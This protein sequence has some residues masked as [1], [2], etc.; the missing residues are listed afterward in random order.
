MT[1]EGEVED[2]YRRLGHLVRKRCRKILRDDALADDALQEAFVRMWRFLSSYRDA[3]SK[4]AWIY[5]V[6]DRCCFDQLARRRTRREDALSGNDLG[7]TSPGQAIEDRDL[8]M[9]L[10]DELDDQSRQIVVLFYIDELS[11][12][13]I[14]SLVGCSRQTVNKKLQDVRARLEENAARTAG[15]RS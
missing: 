4:L 6:A 10:L 9:K 13:E 7:V 5:R 8:A 2:A 11:Q 12:G 15:G 1:D 3:T 14:A